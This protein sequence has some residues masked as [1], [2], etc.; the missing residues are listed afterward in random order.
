MTDKAQFLDDQGEKEVIEAIRQAENKT[1]GEIR[2]HVEAHCPKETKPENR[3]KAV[4]HELKMD[5]TELHNGVLIYLAFNDQNFYIF[6]DDGINDK[7]PDD[8]WESTR[9]VMQA[10]FRTG[11]FKAGLVKGIDKA[12]EQLKTHFPV[13]DDD[14][15]ELSDEISRG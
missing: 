9:D 5:A 10:E 11:D 15:N 1:S 14:I 2:V 13:A 8:F 6:G 4:F 7:V 3:S 12:G